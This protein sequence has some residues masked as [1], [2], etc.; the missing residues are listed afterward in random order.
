MLLLVSGCM[1]VCKLGGRILSLEL[2]SPIQAA[3][4]QVAHPGG[5]S[6]VCGLYEARTVS[7][8]VFKDLDTNAAVKPPLYRDTPSVTCEQLWWTQF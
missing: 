3:G 5:V 6:F 4:Q 7:L 1:A 8:C 2:F